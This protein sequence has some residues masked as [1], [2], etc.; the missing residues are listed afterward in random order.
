MYLTDRE[1]LRVRELLQLIQEADQGKERYRRYRFYNY[2]RK[3]NSIIRTAEAR[4]N[5]P[6]LFNRKT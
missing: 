6:N 4:D 3:I 5:Q 1:V 2:A